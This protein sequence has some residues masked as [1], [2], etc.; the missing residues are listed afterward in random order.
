MPILKWM[1]WKWILIWGITWLGK[2]FLLK[3][4]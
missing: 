4:E 3:E 2:K 1:L